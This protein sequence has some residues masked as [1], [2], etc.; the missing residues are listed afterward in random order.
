MALLATMTAGGE[1]IERFEEAVLRKEAC[2]SSKY[3]HILITTCGW[4]LR[5]LFSFLKTGCH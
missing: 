1:M 2:G 3:H 4:Y 5:R